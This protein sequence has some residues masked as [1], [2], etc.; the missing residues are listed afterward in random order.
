MTVSTYDENAQ[1]HTSQG[2]YPTLSENSTFTGSDDQTLY[3]SYFII[4]VNYNDIV[5]FAI[6]GPTSDVLISYTFATADWITTYSNT[7]NFRGIVP[8]Q[9][10]TSGGNPNLGGL[11]AATSDQG[12]FATVSGPNQT[13]GSGFLLIEVDENSSVTE[14][15]TL[16]MSNPQSGG[17]PTGTFTTIGLSSTNLTTFSGTYAETGG[18]GSISN[19]KLYSGSKLLDQV[20][21]SNG[22]WSFQETLDPNATYNSLYAVITDSNG[23][24]TKVNSPI[25]LVTAAS[26]VNV[27]TFNQG[28][29]GTLILNGPSPVINGFAPGDI[30]D[31]TNVP[32]DSSYG[33][34]YA[35]P[36][37]RLGRDLLAL[38]GGVELAI[39]HG[40]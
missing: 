3:A 21:P 26:Q 7:S 39:H 30:I 40:K 9:E 6:S 24:T 19:V 15:Y 23:N 11:S 4:P 12:G 20:I 29:T 38:L 17:T 2:N 28:S 31:G 37:V 8:W 34:E 13:S 25:S 33:W 36:N 1:G 10:A 14:H 27:A 22:A 32:F 16:N 18:G 35:V 5:N